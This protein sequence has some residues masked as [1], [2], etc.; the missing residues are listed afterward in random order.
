MRLA[1]LFGAAAIG[2]VIPVVFT[3][4]A[5]LGMGLGN[6]R[7]GNAL[8]Q[9]VGAVVSLLIARGGMNGKMWSKIRRVPLWLWL[10]GVIA[11]SGVLGMAILI[12]RI[13]AGNFQTLIVLAGISSGIVIS[14]FGLLSSPVARIN[15]TRVAGIIIMAFGAALAVLGRIPFIDWQ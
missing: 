10:G 11:A 14:H 6:P 15:F 13:G 12:P 4:N 8:I 3:M 7:I 1:R 5:A 2:V 9:V